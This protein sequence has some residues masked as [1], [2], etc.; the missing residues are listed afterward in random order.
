M[1]TLCSPPDLLWERNTIAPDR[2]L[3]NNQVTRMAQ[4]KPSGKGAR[5]FLHQGDHPT[6]Q[7]PSLQPPHCHA[8]PGCSF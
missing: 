1:K 5:F 2:A 7:V 3:N 4:Y 6:P 8:N